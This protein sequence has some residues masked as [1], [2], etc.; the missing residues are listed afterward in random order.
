MNTILTLTTLIILVHIVSFLNF[1]VLNTIKQFKVTMEEPKKSR[2]KIDVDHLAIRKVKRK[3]RDLN[4]TIYY[5]INEKK[6]PVYTPEFLEENRILESELRKLRKLNN[7]FEE[8]NSVLMKYIDTLTAECD[9][10]Y[11]EFKELTLFRNS[12]SS[13]LDLLKSEVKEKFGLLL[14]DSGQSH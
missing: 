10:S 5:E 8:H 4:E 7:D 14:E 3:K 13:Q 11:E 9:Q 12:F 1:I 6:V 2:L